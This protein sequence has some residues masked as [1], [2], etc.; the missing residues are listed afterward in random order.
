[1][2][3]IAI[4]FLMVFGAAGGLDNATDVQLLPLLAIAI[5][6]LIF[7]LFGVRK[8]EQRVF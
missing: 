1:M 2:I 4:G 7:M 3:R 5:T 6:G 8:I